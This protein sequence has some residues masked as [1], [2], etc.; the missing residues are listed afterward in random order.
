MGNFNEA[1][2]TRKGIGLLAKTQAGLTGIGFTKAVAGSGSYADDELLT[3]KT[4]LKD[5]RQEFPIDKLSV[6]NSTTVSIKF[7]ITNEQATGNLQ[8]GY[9]VKEVGLYATDPDEGEILYAIATTVEGQWDYMP[10]FNSLMPTYISVEFYAEVSNSA[11]VTIVCNGRFIT[12]EE[13]E[14][15]LAKL[16]KESE[17]EHQKMREDAKTAHDTLKK[18]IEDAETVPDNV[19]TEEDKGVVNGVASLNHR[20]QVPYE[21]LPDGSGMAY[22]MGA[23]TF[24]RF[25]WESVK[26]SLVTSDDTG[27]VGTYAAEIS[28]P[29]AVEDMLGKYWRE[30]I[31]TPDLEWLYANAGTRADYLVSYFARIAYKAYVKIVDRKV[32]TKIFTGSDLSDS[33][34]FDLPFNAFFLR[35]GGYAGATIY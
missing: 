24:E 19:L 35:G 17:A 27:W 26:D 31:L 33:Q 5:Q 32:T 23:M 20:A 11:N 30:A 18:R 28:L 10:A 4:A 29:E 34:V 16:R 1:V 8:E 14:E 22:Y 6:I 25:T 7:T 21:Q 13:V 2:L 3:D 15:E 12:A 9:Y